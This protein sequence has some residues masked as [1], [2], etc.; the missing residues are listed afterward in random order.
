MIDVSSSFSP[1]LTLLKNIINPQNVSYADVA[2]A[3]A[4]T[5]CGAANS[6]PQEEDRMER[7]LKEVL[8]ILCA[9]E[10]IDE[11]QEG[12]FLPRDADDAKRDELFIRSWMLKGRN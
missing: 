6:P 4:K 3:G 1:I 9:P 10:A 11:P 5:G 12:D 8:E 7:S 2:C